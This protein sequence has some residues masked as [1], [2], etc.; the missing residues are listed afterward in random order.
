MQSVYSTAL[1]DW[2]VLSL[3]QKKEI[4]IGYL[5]SYSY[6]KYL[7]L[8]NCVQIISIRSEYLKLYNWLKMNDD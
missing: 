2:A 4:I 3:E 6:L 5:K 1:A 7:K 8:Y